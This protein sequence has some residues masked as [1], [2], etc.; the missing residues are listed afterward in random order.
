[1]VTLSRF[2]SPQ[3]AECPVTT[4]DAAAWLGNALGGF[5]A[6]PP[7]TLVPG[8]VSLLPW[9]L[10]ELVRG[11]P[12]PNGAQY[13]PISQSVNQGDRRSLRRLAHDDHVVCRIAAQSVEPPSRLI[14]CPVM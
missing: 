2:G 8:P 5:V 12:V 1:M 4:A 13:R 3:S 11:A 6:A 10:G 7:S 14:D 9:R